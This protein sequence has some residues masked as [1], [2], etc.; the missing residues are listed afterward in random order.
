MVCG[1]G[2]GGRARH[3]HGAE[4]GLDLPGQCPLGGQLLSENCC[5]LMFQALNHSGDDP[6]WTSGQEG[7]EVNYPGERVKVDVLQ[8]RSREMGEKGGGWGG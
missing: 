3:C 1:D 5:G 6:E 8:W 7:E 2:G 4:N